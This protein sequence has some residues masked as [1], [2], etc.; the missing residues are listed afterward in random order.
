ME[1]VQLQLTANDYLR[2]ARIV[3]ECKADRLPMV[4]HL[5]KQGGMDPGDIPAI[6]VPTGTD[7]AYRHILNEVEKNREHFDGTAGCEIWGAIRKGYVLIK[8]SELRRI[9]EERGLDFDEI[10]RDLR[11]GDYLIPS[12]DGK[13]TNCTCCHG[14]KARYARIRTE[15][16]GKGGETQ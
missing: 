14:E 8:V 15:T 9:L 11:Y 4:M 7:E 13:Y 2:A 6:T 12:T 5:L 10:K 16:N 3:A 1:Q